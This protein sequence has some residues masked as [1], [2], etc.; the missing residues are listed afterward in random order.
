[1]TRLVVA[2]DAE[3]DTF[4]ILAG[5][6]VKAGAP[7]AER[8]ARRFRDAISRLIEMPRSGAPRPALGTD[9]R[10][11]IVL[12]YLLIYDYTVADDTIVLLRIL[13]GRRRI[14]L[15]TRQRG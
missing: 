3:T 11:V 2:V 10:C 6:E 5:L 14:T 8:Y 9:A 1:M 7:V 4:E 12:P 13:H 15:G